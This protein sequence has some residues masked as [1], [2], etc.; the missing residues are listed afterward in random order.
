MD[1]SAFRG[2]GSALVGLFYLAVA[3]SVGCISLLIY[4]G[5]AWWL[6]PDWQRQAISRGYAIYCPGSGE[7]AWLGECAEPDGQLK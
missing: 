1:G 3:A 2:V 4:I 7:F 5:I 6:E